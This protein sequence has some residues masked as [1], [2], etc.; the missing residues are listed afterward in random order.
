MRFPYQFKKIEPSRNAR[1]N[2]NFTLHCIMLL[3]VADFVIW[4]SIILLL[5]GDVQ[6]NPGPQSISTSSSSTASF[7][8]TPGDFFPSLSLN[9][10]LSFVQYNVQ[11][12]INKLDLL[13]AELFEVDILA[14]TETWL[15]PGTPDDELFLQS[16]NKPE[17][18]DQTDDSHGGVMIYVKEAIHYKRRY[19][20]EIR[21][22]ENIWIEL[23]INRKKILFGLF[24]RPPNSD[25]QHYYRIE[26]SLALATDTGISNII[27]TGDFNYNFL[28]SRTKRKINSFC[29]QF[30]LHQV[31]NQPTHF[32]E[33]SSSFIDIILVNNKEQLILSGVG[34]PFLS[35]DTRYHCPV[36]GI[37]KFAKPKSKVFEREIWNYN[38]G[39]YDLLREKAALVD[40]ESLHDNNI[41]TY[42]CNIQSTIL[43]LA[44]ECIPFKKIK[45]RPFDPPWLNAILKR[46]I[47]KRKRAYKKAK[48]TNQ[49][50]HWTKF[51]N[52]RNE[53]TD[54]LRKSKQSYF[55]KIAEKLTSKSLSPK[56]WWAT[57]K[58][59]ITTTYKSSIPPLESNGH[60]FT[61]E[62]DKAN[63][64]NNFFQSQTILDDANANLPELP[65][66][67]YR[68]QLSN[69]VFTPLEVE[70]IIQSLKTGKA[71]GPNGLSNR[72]LKELY[73]EVS[74]PFSSLFNHSLRLGIFPSCYKDA[75]VSPVPKKGDQSVVSN[76]RPISLLNSESKLFEK[77]IFKHLFNHL[78]A[79]NV[80]SS[81]QSGFI[82]G[83]STVNQ[84]AFLYHTFCEA[85]DN[86][87]EVRA[88]FCDISKAFDRVWHVGLIHKLVA[89]GVTGE[90]LNWF[91]N[92][93]D[94]RRQRVVLPG[95]ISDWTYIRAGVPQ[96]SILGP[97]LF[98]VFINDI[99]VDIGSQIRLFADD[100]SL[101]IIVDDP[102]TAAGCLN[103]DL[104]KIS[105]W[106]ST[107]LV[108][109]NPSK[110]ECLLVS[111]KVNRPQHPPLFMHDTQ[112]DEVDS[113]KH[114]GLFLSQDCT[115]HQ[116]IDFIKEKAWC[117]IN[118]MRKLKFK[119]DRKSLETIYT[120]FVRPL[121]E[122]A[123][124]IWNNCTQYEKT[125]LEKIQLE[126]ARIA[127]G[128]TKLISLN[129]LYKEICWETLEKRRHDHQ[130]TLFYK[131]INNLAPAYLSSL[132]P[133]QV[134]AI[135][136]YNLRNSNDLQTIR[137]KTS[138]YYNSFLPSSIR[139]WNRFPTEGKQCTSVN[140]FKYFLKKDK[141]TAPIYFYYGN[142]KAQVL[143]TRLRTNC[144]SLNLDL[145]LKNI[146]DSPMCLCGSI[147]N[148]QHFF[149]HCRFFQEPRD[150][151]LNAVSLHH[152]PTLKLLLYGEP[153]LSRNSN[154][155]IFRHVHDYILNT[156]R[157]N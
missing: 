59:F 156:R 92:Y 60:V 136:R 109:F 22:T 10:N 140:S 151:L 41:D 102:V 112:I 25:A 113:H 12:I 81:L 116:H 115:W 46:K 5:A 154:E 74:P 149:F 42:A 122:Y 61:D 111:R 24:Y 15:N 106:A 142:R 138:Q 146:T 84:L 130:L 68:T 26:D 20:L 58:T 30:S 78:Q 17:R 103:S 139:E 56:D 43:S 137:T 150:I 127:T 36:F 153:A 53:V 110:S 80:L 52:L 34:E 97:L 7:S 144:S 29:T 123:D 98:L 31:I 16:Y 33:H 117:R 94:D 67:S 55:D 44:K 51:K 63:L 75:N 21:D 131:M 77:L 64:F 129:N 87:K 145:F 69:I 82:P 9:H 70:S 125:E 100:T 2:S 104:E 50:R 85:L 88:V 3:F 119:L 133:Q 89:A 126:A 93:L 48:R 147:E 120:A 23:A 101:F 128:T 38:N 73:K 86:G 1:K 45:I 79:N 28:N 91:K 99:V 157:F 14:F 18:K 19:D 13:H 105:N 32:T 96:G 71:S 11:S 76:Y 66:P 134:N 39:N 121:L 107:W 143:H 83:D 37:L 95:A 148:A 108:T 57:L 6:P 27:V 135:S 40:W 4:L 62:H 49:E 72:I 118:I 54:L 132:I 35:Q 141:Q 47:R 155:N 152:T 90:V 114:L 124:V 65:P 8:T